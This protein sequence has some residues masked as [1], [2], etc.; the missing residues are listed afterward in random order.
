[1]SDEKS[2]ASK[3]TLTRFIDDN[4]KLISTLAILAALSAF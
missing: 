3:S 1:M 2:G 4:H